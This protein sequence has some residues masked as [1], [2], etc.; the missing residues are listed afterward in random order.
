MIAFDSPRFKEP[1]ALRAET[2]RVYEICNGCRRCFNLCPSFDVLFRGIDDKDG[3]VAALDAPLHDRV[4]DLC[5]YCKLCFNHCPYCPPHPYDLD[6]P[7]LM[8]WGKHLMAKRRPAGFRDRLLVNV[9]FVGRLGG[10]IAPLANWALRRPFFRRMLEGV[11]GIHRERLFPDFRWRSFAS[12]FGQIRKSGRSTVG[13]ALRGRTDIGQARGPAPTTEK[14]A[15][16]YTCYV[17]R[18]DPEIGKAAIQVLEK[19]GVE[20]ICPEQECCGMP[21]FDIGDL[22]AVRRKARSNLKRLAAAVDG[23]YKIVS[24]MPTCSLMLKKEYPDLVPTEEARKVAANTYDLCE[25]LMKLEGMGKLAKDFVSSPGKIAYQVPC[26]LRDQN[27]GLK[28]R[29]LMKLIPG[30]TVE[31]IERCSGHDGTFG[32]KKE[33]YDLSLKVGRKAFAAVEN[34]E[35]DVAVSDCPLSG[36]ALTQST[37][38][39]SVHPI[40]VVQKAYGLK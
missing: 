24:P 11:T 18:H 33:F 10:M 17:N 21:Y 25:Y 16:F 7:R 12:W 38:K 27:I 31:V 23:G 35:P 15:L 9:D 1:E 36:I 22:D 29:D 28:S 13:A 26:H 6:F 30:A 34:A 20:V 14:I 4:V 39:K 19:N 2:L 37:G 40:Q 32:V 8:L 5:Y 3:E